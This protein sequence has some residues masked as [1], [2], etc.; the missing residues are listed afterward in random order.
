VRTS[1]NHRPAAAHTARGASS[2][3][4]ALSLA[5]VCQWTSRLKVI[6]R[7]CLCSSVTVVL[8]GGVSAVH[9]QPAICNGVVVAPDRIVPFVAEASQRFAFARS[10][11]RAVIRVVFAILSPCRPK[12]R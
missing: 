5:V 6:R 3:V 4:P 7:L 8:L 2:S 9:A 1:L 10:L 12:A 11:I